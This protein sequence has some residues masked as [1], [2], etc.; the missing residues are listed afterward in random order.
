M[1]SRSPFRELHVHLDYKKRIMFRTLKRDEKKKIL[2]YNLASC[3][4]SM[5]SDLMKN[6]KNPIKDQ[7]QEPSSQGRQKGKAKESTLV[8]ELQRDTPTSTNSWVNS[9]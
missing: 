2:F 6:H 3:N 7:W 5:I 8:G 9:S 4:W 1:D